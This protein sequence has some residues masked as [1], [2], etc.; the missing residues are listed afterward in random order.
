MLWK[1]GQISS[2]LPL[3]WRAE[4]AVGMTC[5]SRHPYKEW[6]TSTG[7][8]PTPVSSIDYQ[9]WWTEDLS[10]SWITGSKH[11][12]EWD[13]AAFE[14]EE[15]DGCLTFSF[16]T[17]RISNDSV[18]KSV[19][20]EASIYQTWDKHTRWTGS[21]TVKKCRQ[22]RNSWRLEKR[23]FSS[24]SFTFSNPQHMIPQV[25]FTKAGQQH[26]DL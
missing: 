24:K 21:N 2:G 17:S 19:W 22:N 25:C 10:V 23:Y 8:D 16:R 15:M 3:T 1:K 26:G 7:T 4:V 12:M 20:A 11:A 5:R 9:A 6:R 14:L 18:V 13:A